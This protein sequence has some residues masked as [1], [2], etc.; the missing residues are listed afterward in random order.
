MKLYVLWN[1]CLNSMLAQLNSW[2]RLKVT[3]EIFCCLCHELQVFPG[4]IRLIAHFGQKVSDVG[5]DSL[6]CQSR[7]HT[8]KE[9]SRAGYGKAERCR[10]DAA[11]LTRLEICYVLRFVEKHGRAGLS[12]PWSIR[13]T[14]IYQQYHFEAGRSRWILIQAPQA[15]RNRLKSILEE[16]G[17][18]TGQTEHHPVAVHLLFLLSCEQKWKSYLEY[19]SEELYNFVCGLLHAYVGTRG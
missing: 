16:E 7:T 18:R 12:D 11:M 5:D 3:L 17:D 6:F 2:S 14:G 15:T 4:F 1:D 9:Q 13:K 19:L 8:L 10:R